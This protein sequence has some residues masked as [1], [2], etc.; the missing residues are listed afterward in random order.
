MAALMK[1]MS[2]S[3][4]SNDYDYDYDYAGMGSS[5]YDYDY[6][7][8]YDY[9]YSVDDS[10]PSPLS[11]ILQ[12]MLQ[13]KLTKTAPLQLA[14]PPKEVSKPKVEPAS[15]P[16]EAATSPKPEKPVESVEISK[17]DDVE[18]E[19]PPRPTKPTKGAHRIEEISYR[20]AP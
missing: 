5:E 8:G 1:K 13:S 11:A 18:I 2:S 15:A 17:D 16:K 6:G 14:L 10:A 9:D 20:S 19:P 7:Y 4:S 12:Q 3:S